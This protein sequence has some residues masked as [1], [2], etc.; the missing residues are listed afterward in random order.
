MN[1]I[2][3]F[4]SS[5]C[6]DLSQVRTDL[7][8]FISNQGHMP[9]LSE[10]DNFPINP[11]KKTFDNCIEAVRNNADIFILI[12][13]NRYGSLM[14]NEKSI[15][16]T[17]FLTARI[18]NI[19]IFIFIDKKT[20]S[21]YSIWKENKDA[22]FSKFVDNKKIF[23]FISEVR[24][25]SKL[26]SY[27]FEKA[28]DIILIL[29]NQFSYFFKESLTIYR[30]YNNLDSSILGL[31]LSNE[32]INI[33]LE[34]DDL[35]EYE[36]FSKILVE[37]MEKSRYLKNDM[38]YR[39]HY[40]STD[41]IFDDIEVNNWIRKRIPTLSNLIDSFSNLI[42]GAFRDFINEPGHPA[43]LK[44][45]YYVA[46][47]Y[48]KAFQAVIQWTIDTRNAVVPDECENLKECFSLYSKKC[49]EQI[50]EY[51][52]YIDNQLLGIKERLKRGEK[53][54]TI[55]LKINIEIDDEAI[56]KF[57]SEFK[58]YKERMLSK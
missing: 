9:V 14:D 38:Q 48:S 53:D 42:N 18:K 21:A 4:V 49:I 33:L 37:E 16:N 52:F 43:D 56:S 45:L 24:D 34:K 26:W 7:S 31:N 32:A 23:E 13:G 39:I 50:W 5:T 40:E 41:V 51:P 35:Y 58:K 55:D 2:N 22:D 10:F 11:H 30:K 8:E 44:G 17:E 20:L 15:T 19:P 28:Q 3:I 57:N 47:A 46:K 1:R 54:F 27:E 36:F 25:D 29:K 6:Y 12:V